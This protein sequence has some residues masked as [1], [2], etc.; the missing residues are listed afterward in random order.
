MAENTIIRKLQQGQIN[1]LDQ[2]YKYRF[3]TTDLLQTTLGTKNNSGLYQKLQIL[4]KQK[5]VGKRYKPSDRYRRVK[6]SYY[7]LPK[8]LRALQPLPEHE[9][10]DSKLIKASYKDKTLSDRFVRRTLRFY[11]VVLHLQDLYPNLKFFS[12]REIARFSYFPRPLPDGFLSIRLTESA[13][14]KRYLVDCIYTEMPGYA[15]K[16]KLGRI[17]EF[18]KEG[19][20]EP[21]RSKLPAIIFLCDNAKTKKRVQHLITNYLENFEIDNLIVYTSTVLAVTSA[22]QDNMAVWSDVNEP[23]EYLALGEF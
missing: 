17:I 3:T 22:T 2:I 11:D 1:T 16:G 8:G 20:W 19:G 6:A 23:D 9:T 15:I 10:I 7:L 13:K 5:Y 21:T 18:F 12:K 14:P 4:V